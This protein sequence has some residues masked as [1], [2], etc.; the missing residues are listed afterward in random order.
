MKYEDLKNMIMF[1]NKNWKIRGGTVYRM[2]LGDED[3]LLY[4]GSLK[5]MGFKY[6]EERI[7]MVGDQ[8]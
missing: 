3:A 8:V 1:N 6:I 4:D 5:R 2:F 7:Q